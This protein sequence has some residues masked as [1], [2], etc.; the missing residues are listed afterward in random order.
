MIVYLVTLIILIGFYEVLK[1][2]TS[3]AAHLIM[4]ALFIVAGCLVSVWFEPGTMVFGS[5]FVIIPMTILIGLFL[6]PAPVNPAAE[7]NRLILCHILV[8][9]ITLI[10][11]TCLVGS[12]S[13]MTAEYH[14]NLVL[15]NGITYTCIVAFDLV[16]AIGVFRF[17]HSRN[18]LPLKTVVSKPA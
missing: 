12:Y 3:R 4:P 11:T 1:E 6:L 14:K 13:L 2:T 5:H 8:C 7:I 17:L 18:I 16:L 15:S 9:V 10:A